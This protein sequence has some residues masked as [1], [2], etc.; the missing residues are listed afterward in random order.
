MPA[1]CRRDSGRTAVAT[2]RASPDRARSRM[3]L[4]LAGVV[5]V[6]AATSGCLP[7]APAATPTA[8]PLVPATAFPFPS[9]TDA[10]SGGP[11]TQ[12]VQW[13]FTV[14][15]HADRSADGSEDPPLTPAGE[16]RAERLAEYLA[17][18]HGVAV[19][20][21]PY[22]RTQT[23]AAPTA[24]A[25]QVP[26]TAYNAQTD[27]TDLVMGIQRQHAAGP[28]LI[29]GHSDTV[30][31]IVAELCQCEVEP[32]DENDFGQRYEVDLGADGTVLRADQTSDY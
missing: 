21:T 19:Y 10:P 15:R 32:I 4:A 3:G 1:V 6:A 18:R 26:V 23:T 31:A 12:D 11:A 24:A 28:V 30:P 20:A 2:V 9:A 5:L 16:Q 25:W 17:D 8:P 29:V 13:S 14:V 22:R 7:A 27:A